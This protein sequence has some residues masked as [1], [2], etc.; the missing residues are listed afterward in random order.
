MPLTPAGSQQLLRTQQH[1]GLACAGLVFEAA[2]ALTS[3]LARL[4]YRRLLWQ[5]GLQ[6]PSQVMNMHSDL[7]CSAAWSN[8]EC[9]SY[10]E[11]T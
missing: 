7:R 2:L 4:Q 11:K 1:E 9:R 8:R 10:R 5:Q 3:F 6:R